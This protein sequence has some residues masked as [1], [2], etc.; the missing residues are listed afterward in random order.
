MES[1]LPAASYL[2]LFFKR[3]REDYYRALSRV[4]TEGDWEGWTAFFLEGVATI[5]EEAVQAA[6]ELFALV[7]S[8]RTRVLA[9][10]KA[11]VVASRLFEELPAIRS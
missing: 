4:R 9:A 6:R 2:S 7:S 5:A 11:S 10:G 3:R 8:D 1:A